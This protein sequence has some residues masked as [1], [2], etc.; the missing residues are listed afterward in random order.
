MDLKKHLILYSL[1]LFS[2]NTYATIPAGD[3][4]L[5]PLKTPSC[6][7]CHGING[8]AT[9]DSYPNL[10]GQKAPYLFNGM[11]SYQNGEREGGLAEMMKK[12]LS[13]LNDQDLADIAAFYVQMPKNEK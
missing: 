10:Q 9:Q 11:K 7:F 6:R 4:S 1:F 13:K 8:V 12:Q 5:G 3:A 2:M